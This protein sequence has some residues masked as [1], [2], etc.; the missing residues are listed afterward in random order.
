MDECDFNKVSEG[1]ARG[2]YS[3]LLGA[4]ASIGSIGGNGELLPS[5]PE[6]RDKLVSEFS[7]PVEDQTIS[8]HRAY[9]AAKRSNP[10]RLDSFMKSWFSGCK[11]DWQ[12]VL[13]DFEWQR[14]WTLN[15]D[16]I[17][18][19]VYQTR[20]V[21]FDRFDWT[22]RFR[23]TANSGQ[24]IIHLHGYVDEPESEP[25]SELVFSISEYATT[26]QDPKAWHT[27]FTD[28][29]GERPFI[30]LGASLIDEYDLQQALTN[31]AAA[32]A[33]GFPSVIVLKTISALERAELEEL[34]LF[35][36]EADA[37]SF[38]DDI[39]LRTREYAK[40]LN[41]LYGRSNSQQVPTFLQQ[42]DDLR[43]YNPLHGEH[44]RHFYSGYEPHWRNILDED[45]CRLEATEGSFAK[46]QSGS[47]S[48]DLR[49][50]IHVLTG[51]SGTGKSTALLRIA[52]NCIAAGLP[53]FRF[54]AEEDLDVEATAQW[55]HQ[56]PNSV[57]IFNDCADF[58]DSLGELALRCKDSNTNL[59]AVGA[60]RTARRK[61][62]EQKITSPFLHLE[63]IYEYRT[64]SNRDID[65]LI[66]KLSSRTRLG[67]IT[68][69]SKA[70]QRRYFRR[71]AS[72]R[73]FEGLADLEG[74]VGFQDRIKNN[75]L[76]I[77]DDRIRNLY[78]ASSI[79]YEFGYPLPAAIAA[80]V[81]GLKTT[82]LETILNDDEQDVMIW[83]VNGIHPPHRMTA[84]MVVE[85]A[86]P[87]DERVFAIK[88]LTTALAPHI[89]RRAI[90]RLTL[91]YRLIRRL[92]DQETIV[93]LVGPQFGREVYEH[94]E[95]LYD[96]NGRYWEQRALFES[97]LGNHPQARS[98]AEYSL[99]IHWHPFALNTLGTVLGRIA[100]DN[101]D[102]DAL[103]D[104]IEH[105]ERARDQRRWD[106]SEHPYVTF[107]STMIKF[108][109]TWGLSAIP[110][111]LRQTFAEWYRHA[112]RSPAFAHV[113]T[114]GQL[115]QFQV[116]WL[117]LATVVSND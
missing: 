93:R 47:T 60:E 117:T 26:L 104:A 38:M 67:K 102:S 107:F 101:G 51:N 20:G 94:M 5:G 89:D 58:A 99:K 28:E 96:W 108:G 10:G 92:M 50:G 43:R 4:G 59:L 25:S 8:L 16:D 65:S 12:N 112:Q 18:E 3:L 103:R 84:R 98:Y 35:V 61:F 7:I 100:V 69:W 44:S 42:F 95:A 54:R 90:R 48:T 64:L 57:L 79:A 87:I 66:D 71:T 33:R 75:Y 56:M 46:I 37:R 29:F 105:L 17:I 52:R 109:E 55:L 30:I 78:A 41:Q 113:H 83:G 15:I 110:A 72:R 77:K 116:D 39:G 73:L 13:A 23:D 63:P 53:T 114:S 22:S 115:E 91:P 106:E 88:S 111:R 68:R 34:G 11:P 85:S 31:S 97:S 45:D 80:R 40:L 6:L 1:V 9:A 62:L 14:I 76:H 36:I 21:R 32:T 81:A 19:S 27:V 2:E 74:G 70:D 86:L 82:E 49:Q 24:Q